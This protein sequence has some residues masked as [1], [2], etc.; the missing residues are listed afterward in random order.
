MAD[1][2][3]TFFHIDVNSAFLSWT[4]LEWLHLGKDV[5]LRSVPSIVGGDVEKR[6]GIVLAKS[7]PAKAY[8][9]TTGEPV[10]SALRKCPGLIVASPDHDMYEQ[11]SHQLMTYLQTISPFIEQV[12]I[13][14]CYM[15]ADSILSSYSS[16][17][18]AARFIRDSVH[19]KFGFT[20]NIGISDRKILAKM[21]SDFQKPNKI[22]TLYHK[23]IQEKMWPL[24][25]SSLFLCGKSAT[26]ELKK[27]EILTIGDLA[28][29]D[30]EILSLNLK[31]QGLLLWRYANGIDD[32]LVNPVRNDLKGIGNSMTLVKDALTPSDVYG[33]LRKLCDT[34]SKRLREAKSIPSMISVEIKYSTFVRNTHQM[35]LKNPTNT[36]TELFAY[37]CLL[38]DEMW[39]GTPVRLL[40]VRT[41]KFTGQDSQSVQLSLFDTPSIVSAHTRYQKLDA[42][43]DHLTDKYGMGIVK[44]AGQLLE[45]SEDCASS[46]KK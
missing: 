2:T 43:L 25:V 13:D 39:D 44:R 11:Q 10:V 40:G 7:V 8:H 22:H 18:L 27:L 21:A 6:H 30:P 26:R 1:M 4:A 3:H 5:D 14:E 20:V 28:K 17:L 24:P 29:T 19:E 35:T 23:E 37:S 9:I 15:D 34:V 16:A 45:N 36:S 33:C 46:S 32:S 12:S 31:S 38:F 42:A 41:T